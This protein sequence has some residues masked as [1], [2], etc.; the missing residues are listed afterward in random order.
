M[1]RGCE[2]RVVA[3]GTKMGVQEVMGICE[4]VVC[5]LK[6]PPGLDELRG[7]SGGVERM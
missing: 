6:I 5:C 4:S 1:S 3:H 2:S 7:W